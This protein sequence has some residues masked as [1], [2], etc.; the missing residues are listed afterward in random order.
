M[1]V[2]DESQE[3]L[4]KIYRKNYDWHNDRNKGTSSYQQGEPARL[5][6]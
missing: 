2:T 6:V 3:G 5:L 4:A 1:P